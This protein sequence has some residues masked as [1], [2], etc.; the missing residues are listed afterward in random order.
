MAK[1][2]FLALREPVSRA[3]H[4]VAIGLGG[5]FSAEHGVGALKR[6]ELVR[7]RGGTELKLMHS[8]KA[9][10]DPRGLMNPGKLL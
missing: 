7:Y 6:D 1:Q 10:I 2:A 3:V 9:A 5:S 4:D 8:I